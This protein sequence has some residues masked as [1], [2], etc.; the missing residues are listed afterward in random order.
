MKQIT[1]NLDKSTNIENENKMREKILKNKSKLLD[2]SNNILSHSD[3]I[4]IINK[5]YLNID[6]EEKKFII[7]ELKSKI[8]GYK[9]QDKKKEYHDI[10]NLI[11]LDDIIEKLVK[12]KLRCY[13]CKENV[14]IY[15]KNVR[16]NKQWTLDRIN[17]YDEHT[18]D[19]TVISCLSCNLQ[20]RRKSSEKFKFSKQLEISKID[21]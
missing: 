20:R 15:Y 21:N 6:S 12:C 7:S 17:N 9:Q 10:E 13:Y 1:F 16:D 2:I 14:Y 5:L 19:N 18:S 3:Q 11:T 8:N 4:S